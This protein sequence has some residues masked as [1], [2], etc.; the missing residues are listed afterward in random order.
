MW[1]K[2]C[3]SIEGVNNV[4]VKQCGVIE[5]INECSFIDR[6]TGEDGKCQSG[7]CN[8]IPKPPPG[9]SNFRRLSNKRLSL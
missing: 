8:V 1:L 3:K 2:K 4:L 6:L 5:G 7:Q 9:L